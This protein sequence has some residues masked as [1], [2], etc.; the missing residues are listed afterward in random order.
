MSNVTQDSR[1]PGDN[2]RRRS[3][4]GKNRNNQSNNNSENHQGGERRSGGDRGGHSQNRRQGGG[5]RSEEFRP[6]APRPARVY[7]APKL[8]FW[9]KILKAIGLYKEPARPERT[10]QP[11]SSRTEARVPKSNTRVA[12]S[13]DGAVQEKQARPERQPRPERG[14]RAERPERGERQP[15][16]RTRGGN[17][18]SVE[19]PR[20]YVGNLSYDVTEEDLKELFKGVGGVRN[21]EIVYNRSTHR[22]KGYGFLEMLNMDDAMRSVEVLNDQFFM[23]RKLTVSGAKAKGNDEREEAEERPER[24]PRPIVVAS[25]NR[26]VPVVSE[27]LISEI[28]PVTAD[29]APV[30]AEAASDVAEAAPVV[31]EATPVT[32]EIET[33]TAEAEP[34][35]ETI[36]E[37]VADAPEDLEARYGFD[38]KEK[39]EKA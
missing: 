25:A 11:T 14:E 32:A 4:G 17:R 35:I 22:S 5:N 1:N 12:R 30:V 9:Q 21:V 28:E 37:Q 3:R 34:K 16:E 38:D 13:N 36:V 8:S 10:L 19:S 39:S 31:V 29:A 27:S 15:R 33:V 18:D 26:P 23:G 6:Q 2:K 7:S 24:E 20:V